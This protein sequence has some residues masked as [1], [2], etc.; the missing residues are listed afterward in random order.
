MSDSLKGLKPEGFFRWFEEICRIPHVMRHEEQ[1]SLFL[2]NFAK[3]RGLSCVR[4]A[5][6]NVFITVGVIEEIL[7]ALNAFPGDF[8]GILGRETGGLGAAVEIDHHLLIGAVVG[9]DLVQLHTG[10]E[11]TFRV[12]LDTSDLPAGEHL[13]IVTLTTNSPLRP[14]VNLFIAGYIE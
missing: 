8:V 12:H 9:K 4:Y 1:I 5:M 13:T 3:D 11:V 14:I 10:E 6:G 7:H 2:E